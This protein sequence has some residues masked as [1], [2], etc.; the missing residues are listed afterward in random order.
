MYKATE[1]SL[2]FVLRVEQTDVTCRMSALAPLEHI[3]NTNTKL[4]QGLKSK[5]ARLIALPRG[6]ARNRTYFFVLFFVAW[7]HGAP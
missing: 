1:R 2:L 6:S 7:S 3:K 4:A 5:V